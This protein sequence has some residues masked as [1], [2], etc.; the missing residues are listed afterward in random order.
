MAID[1]MRLAGLLNPQGMI[2]PE[3]ANYKPEQEDPM[4]Y[5]QDLMNPQHSAQDQLMQQL[6]GMPQRK[7]YPNSTMQKIMAG[8]AGMANSRPSAVVGG[9]PVG[10]EADIP[11]GLAVQN[12]LLDRRYNEAL[13][14]WN[15]KLKPLSE[16]SDA[17]R[18]SNTNRRMYG[19]ALITD[20]NKD[21][22]RESREKL[23][24]DKIEQQRLN[25]E[26]KNQHLKY[27]EYKQAH[28]NKILRSTSEG[29]VYGWDPQSGKMEYVYDPDGN[30]VE[31]DKLPE[32]EKL[33]IQQAN[34][35]ERIKSTGGERMKQ[36]EKGIEGRESLENL[37]QIGRKENIKLTAEEGIKR[38]AVR[39]FAP[40]RASSKVTIQDQNM[41]A[42]QIISRDPD[43]ERYITFTDQGPRINPSSR[44]LDE[45]KR[46]ALYDEIF[47][48]Q[49]SQ[50]PKTSTPASTS[51]S[52]STGKAIPAGAK[53]GGKWITTKYGDVYQEP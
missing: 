21:K 27:L 45:K 17:E 47:V 44:S 28:P 49:N 3:N 24:A 15:Q 37:Q 42:N 43:A 11:S 40:S 41:I 8:I 36:I 19:S 23:A 35:L 31:S 16:L 22:D 9:Q 50:A 25:R 10:Y 26:Q 53:P 14:D 4:K 32:K 38:D 46:L 34:A 33:E 20:A 51:T 2:P 5:L 29:Y 48:R 13:S 6:Q 39:P 18:A 1:F 52:T 12:N 7:D 30:I